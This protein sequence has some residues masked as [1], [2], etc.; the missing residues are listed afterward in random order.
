MDN[1]FTKLDPITDDKFRS[2]HQRSFIARSEILA[3]EARAEEDARLKVIQDKKD[4]IKAIL[5]EAEEALKVAE[6]SSTEAENKARPLIKD[7]DT[8]A[9]E[10]KAAASA[11][12]ETASSIEGQMAT[13][14]EKLKQ[15]KDAC[16]ETAELKGFDKTETTRLNAREAKIKA[17]LTKI[18]A[19][20]KLAREKAV[21][22]AFGEIDSK[23][24]E[25]VTAIRAKMTED[26][27][28][29]AEFYDSINGGSV[30]NKEKFAEF[31]KGLPGMPVLAEGVSDKL[32]MHIA[33][34]EATEIGKDR[35][36]EMVRLYYKVVKATVLSEELSIKSKTVRRLELGEVLE[37]MEAPKKE[38]AA[39]V[40]RVRCHSVQDD[41]DGWVTLAGNQG[42][43][44]LE[45]GGNFYSCVKETL[46]TDGL[47]V[48][49]SKTVRR[50]AKGEVIQVLEFPKK[51]STSDVKRIKGKAKLDGE[52]GWITVSSSTGT[53]FLEPC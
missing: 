24:A 6:A 30:L 31:M 20:T 11:V 1:I 36:L 21:R 37:A 29:G 38:E 39:G 19:A 15:A 10:I 27:K 50:I 13:C 49:E 3:R 42:T 34:E 16:E 48:S 7:S 45:P 4:A 28:S 41:A 2:L 33:G 52:V 23:R 53:A 22:K 32:F 40:E 12:E 26:G 35:F 8:P 51:D 9:D 25:A 44:F 43:A 18:H 5:A 46:L 17:R 14:A 47:S